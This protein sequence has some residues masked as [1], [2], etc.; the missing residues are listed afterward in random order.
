MLASTSVP[1]SEYGPARSTRTWTSLPDEVRGPSQVY[2]LILTVA[3]A[4]P[5]VPLGA[6]GSP[7][8]LVAVVVPARSVDA[9]D[10]HLRRPSDPGPVARPADPLLH[11]R[12]A[13]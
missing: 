9:V 7:A 13:R 5:N 8:G 12:A 6:P 10:Q 1:V 2:E 11:A 3:A 4:K